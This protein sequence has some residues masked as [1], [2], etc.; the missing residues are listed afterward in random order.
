MDADIDIYKNQDL[1]AP[2]VFREGFNNFQ[3]INGNQA[4][5]LLFTGGQEDKQLEGSPELGRFF[6]YSLVAVGVSTVLWGTS[7]A[8]LLLSC[9]GFLGFFLLFELSD[10]L[11][12]HWLGVFLFISWRTM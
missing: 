10:F 5:S 4:W 6:T 8:A 11:N 2:V 1:F 3:A 9:K 7:S 12:T